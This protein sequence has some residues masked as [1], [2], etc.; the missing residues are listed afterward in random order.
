MAKGEDFSEAEGK[1][2]AAVNALAR[3]RDA[4]EESEHPPE[5]NAGLTEDQVDW[6]HRVGRLVE[7]E[8]TKNPGCREGLLEEVKNSSGCSKVAKEG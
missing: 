6:L 2:L 8:R 1:L 4:L 7:R 5:T 3:E